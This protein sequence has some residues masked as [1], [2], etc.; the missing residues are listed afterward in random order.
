MEIDP[1]NR[2][3]RLSDEVPK[4]SPSVEYFQQFMQQFRQQT[5]SS[6]D[7]VIPIGNRQ[8]DLRA[9]AF[10]LNPDGIVSQRRKFQELFRASGTPLVAESSYQYPEPGYGDGSIGFSISA[11][12]TS[13]RRE[14]P[15]AVD[16]LPLS[17]QPLNVITVIRISKSRGIDVASIATYSATGE[18]FNV[19]VDPLKAGSYLPPSAKPQTV[20]EVIQAFR[21]AGGTERNRLRCRHA[22]PALRLHN[23]QRRRRALGL[24]V[25]GQRG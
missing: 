4:G 5:R 18:L 12:R 21:F 1:G 15:K 22:Q 19:A 20:D 25:S 14:L 9:E 17:A 10:Y 11:E 2:V 8:P 23:R 7:R 24:Q 3:A 16:E 13:I 6:V